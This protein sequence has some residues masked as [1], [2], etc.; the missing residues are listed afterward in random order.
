MKDSGFATDPLAALRREMTVQSGTVPEY[1][2]DPDFD[3]GDGFQIRDTMFRAETVSG[4]KFLYRQG[5][6]LTVD[7]PDSSLEDEFRMYLVGAVLGTVSWMNGLLPLHASAV[8]RDGRAMAFTA[9]SG[10]GKSTLA[11]SLASRGYRHVCDDTLVLQCHDSRVLALPDGKPR[12]LWGDAIEHL[13][14]TPKREIA[15]VPGK[16]YVEPNESAT[17]PLPLTDLVFLEF[18]EDLS[19]TPIR[20]ADKMQH[21]QDALYF[22]FVQNAANGTMENATLMTQL[23][24]NVRFWRGC[25]PRNME[26][27]SAF[28]DILEQAFAKTV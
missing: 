5:E 16:F 1:L 24:Q 23:A 28:S 13:G 4:V 7:L 12:K 19:I 14:A 8:E 10:G 2:A 26:F 15:F 17:E 25:R 22:A 3:D 6:G 18:G 21:I 27:A 20:G 9:D 11:A